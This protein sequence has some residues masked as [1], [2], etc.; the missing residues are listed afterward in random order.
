LLES[1]LLWEK[2]L[3]E[4][5]LMLDITAAKG[6]DSWFKAIALVTAEYLAFP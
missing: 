3:P 5:Q 4:R 6:H 2:R 1:A